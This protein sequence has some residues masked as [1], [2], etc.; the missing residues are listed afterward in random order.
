MAIMATFSGESVECLPGDC[1]SIGDGG[2]SRGQ[3]ECKLYFEN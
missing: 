3:H 1:G 2:V